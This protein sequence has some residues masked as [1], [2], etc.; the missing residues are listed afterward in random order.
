[1]IYDYKSQNTVQDIASECFCPIIEDIENAFVLLRR[2]EYL[3]VY[4]PAHIIKKFLVRL[5]AELDGVFLYAKSHDPFC[6]LD[7]REI[8]MTIAYDGM[9]C[10]EAAR[11]RN[12]RLKRA[13]GMLN[14]VHDTFSQKDIDELS[15]D[16]ASILVFGLIDEWEEEDNACSKYCL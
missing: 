1:M 12:G 8:V 13:D 5:L 10:A 16:N 11:L 15:W 7:N 3:A 6:F 4:A 9:I 14:Y 2:G